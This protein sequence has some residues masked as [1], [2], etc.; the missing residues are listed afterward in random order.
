MEWKEH[1]RTLERA[2]EWDLAIVLMEDIIKQNPNDMD[3]YIF[4]NYLLMNLLQRFRAR[5]YV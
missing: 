3:A 2:K 5:I 4:M 1:L